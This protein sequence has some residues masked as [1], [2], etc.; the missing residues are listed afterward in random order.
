MLDGGSGI[1][2]LF[3]GAGDYILR[4]G[5]S[6][7][8][9][10]LS[11]AEPAMTPSSW[12]ELRVARNTSGLQR[13]RSPRF[14][15]RPFFLRSPPVPSKATACWTTMSSRAAIR[16]SMSLRASANPG[17]ATV[18]YTQTGTVVLVGVDLGD[19]RSQLYRH[20]RNILI[21]LCHRQRWPHT[22]AAPRLPRSTDNARSSSRPSWCR[23]QRACRERVSAAGIHRALFHAPNGQRP[24][25]V[26]RGS[27]G[28]GR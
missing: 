15:D 28:K 1:D 14:R 6:P 10:V 8:A 7:S 4:G 5:G 17:D 12:Q 22:P 21:G 20:Q 13:G 18:T 25:R 19:H 23:A 24:A 3:G 11:T 26:R 2:V 16:P 27:A 9:D